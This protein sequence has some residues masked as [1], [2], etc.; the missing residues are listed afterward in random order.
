MTET[1]KLEMA[2]TR[3]GQT[4]KIIAEKIGISN[5]GFYKKINNITEFK[6]SEIAML[7]RILQ[8]SDDERDAIF[9]AQKGDLKSTKI[10]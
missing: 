2:I 3:S 7:Q 1:V 9:F 10:Y 6:A 4:K 5:M 8:L